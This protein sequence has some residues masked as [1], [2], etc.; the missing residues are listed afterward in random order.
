LIILKKQNNMTQNQQKSIS[1][2]LSLVLRHQPEKIGL[3]L[4]ENGWADVA[5][6]LRLS[7]NA[8]VKFTLEDLIEIVHEND[9][10]RFV[11]S[12]GNNKIRA[13]QGHSVSIDL[14]LDAIVPPNTLYHGT[15]I[16]NLS[17]IL[18][19]GIKKQNRQHVHLSEDMDT[20][21][22]VG[23]RHGKP[24]VLCINTVQ[25]YHDGFQF[26]KSENNVWLT[27][28]VPAKYLSQ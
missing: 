7:T 6:L 16:N 26:F 2:F 1:K 3:S 11:F 9:K 20:A 28:F 24:V 15:A 19:E 4:D 25:M 18:K 13:N 5:E 21:A 27:D 8:N 12:E 22:K 10:Q 14:A 23:S 17:A